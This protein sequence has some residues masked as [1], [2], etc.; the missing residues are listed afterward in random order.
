MPGEVLARA[1]RALGVAPREVPS[2]TDERAGRLR[3]LLVGRRLLL[4]IDGVGHAAQVRPLLPAG[5]GPALVVVGLR[6]LR[7]LDGTAAL[8]VGPM[9]P[10]DAFNLLAAYVG[11]ERLTAEPTAT[12]ELIR[13]CAGSPLALRIAGSLLADRPETPIDGAV[14]QLRDPG[15]RLDWLVYEDLSVRQ[16]LATAHAALGATDRL[17]AHALALFGDNEGT[18][19]SVDTI[20]GTLGV[21]TARAAR[22]LDAL[23]D[24]HLADRNAD[25]YQLRPLVRDYAASIAARPGAQR[26]SL[27]EWRSASLR[28]A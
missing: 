1:L 15:E 4:V 25:G 24:A 21:S 26:H 8:I 3:S 5:P 20:A 9:G 16:S 23:V 10:V 14:T 22:A 11:A 17:A 2:S 12:A 28:T 18:S 27:N 6:D 7:S 13:L 19:R